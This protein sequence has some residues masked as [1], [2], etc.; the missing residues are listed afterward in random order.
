MNAALGR[1]FPTMKKA[2]NPVPLLGDA[3]AALALM[4]VLSSEHGPGLI[5]SS[6]DSSNEEGGQALGW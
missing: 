1:L 5:R 4:L 6:V 2:A 3:M